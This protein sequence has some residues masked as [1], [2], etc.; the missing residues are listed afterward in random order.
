MYTLIRLCLR[1]QSDQGLHGLHM[2]FYVRTLVFE[3]LDIYHTLRE[4]FVKEQFDQNLDY[5]QF[6]QH[7]RYVSMVTS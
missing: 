4:L 2:P 5:L 1:E 7:F 6:S 3:V